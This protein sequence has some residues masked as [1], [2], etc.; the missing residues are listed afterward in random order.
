MS[1]YVIDASILLQ[2]FEGTEESRLRLYTFLNAENITFV[3]PEFVLIEIGNVLI[4]KKKASPER[5][6]Q[7]YEAVISYGI[8]FMPLSFNDIYAVLTRASQLQTSAY[9]GQYLFLAEKENCPLITADGELL[10]LKAGV[11]LSS[12]MA[13]FAS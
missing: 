5:L 9:D 4:K 11:S 3:A 13:D 2:L 6:Y 10:K 12:V 1:R 8:Q 7:A